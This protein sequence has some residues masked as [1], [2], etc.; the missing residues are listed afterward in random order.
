MVQ[1][2]DATGTVLGTNAVMV[3]IRKN[4]QTLPAPERIVFWRHLVLS[5]LRDKALIA[6]FATSMWLHR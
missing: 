4:A 5:T 1:A 3:R 2:A 6:T